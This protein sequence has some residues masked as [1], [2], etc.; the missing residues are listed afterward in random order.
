MK[1]K[2]AKSNLTIKVKLILLLALSIGTIVIFNVLSL[3]QTL[4]L[5]KLQDE[6]Y[7]RSLDAEAVIEVKHGL[8][9]LY[10]IAADMI[11]NGYSDELV[12]EYNSVQTL[13]NNDL[14]EVKESADTAVEKQFIA[15]AIE[16]SLEFEKIV[17]EELISGLK[18]K[19]LSDSDFNAIDA[20]LDTLKAEYFD[21]MEQV[22]NSLKEEAVV[23]DKAYDQTSRLGITLS[24]VIGVVVSIALAIL[25]G[26]IIQSI[27]KS[28]AGVITI[29]NKQATLDF[30]FDENS[31]ILKYIHRKDEIGMMT[32]ALKDMEDT[33]RTFVIKTAEASEQ[34][35]STSEE[36]TATSQQS[37]NA[38]EEVAKTIEEIARGASDQAKD[39]EETAHN[40][41]ELGKLLDAE[42]KLLRDL[43]QAALRIETQK[44]E[45]F[46]ILE[47]LIK[48]TEMTNKSSGTIYDM[49]IKNNESAEKIETSSVMI[50][51]IASQ[52]N[53]LALNA[54]IEA[55]R[56]GEAGRGFAV[57]ADEIRKLAEQSNSFTS[58]IKVVIN[59]LKTKSQLAVD[60]M[61]VVKRNLDGQSKSVGET[62]NKFKGIAEAIDSV[63]LII[64]QL[65]HS[66]RQMADNK[67]LIIE[68]I[69]NLSAIAEENA[70]GTQEASASI[71]EQTS[72]IEEFANSSEELSKIAEELRSLI[73]KFVV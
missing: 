21:Y 25:M 72:A 35:A 11:I 65:N 57:V 49:I 53:L 63:K 36:L 73:Q 8:N 61:N 31:E 10:S 32:N 34:V 55:A 37:A 67:D 64:G 6:S 47:D 14:A 50:E 1:E 30:S 68:L 4:N 54:A 2:K 41:E 62:E 52:T 18:S 9:A 13:V 51:N 69:Q 71:E 23:S 46:T 24:I 3:V 5:G 33:V 26:M 39:T 70:A 59:D 66:S 44:E 40:V 22:A 38:S 15:N 60:E 48:K 16:H 20:K 7:G 29:I 42:A 58:D 43:N 17:M 19:S 27:V 56:A 12:I 28:I 45:G